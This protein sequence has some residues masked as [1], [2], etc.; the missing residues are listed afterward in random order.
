MCYY[1]IT[2]VL[3]SFRNN[4]H[5]LIEVKQISIRKSQPAS[6]I[7]GFTSAYLSSLHTNFKTFQ[8]SCHP[9]KSESRIKCV[10]LIISHV[11]LWYSEYKSSI[12][13]IC[14]KVLKTQISPINL[15]KDRLNRAGKMPVVFNFDI[16]NVYEMVAYDWLY[17]QYRGRLK[18]VDMVFK[19]FGNIE[20]WRLF[21]VC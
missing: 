10:I 12:Q 7:N 21:L 2:C 8:I 1:I 5:R 18:I 15:L 16:C 9:R 13:N 14:R 20:D 4:M 19:F 6:L 17:S 11:Y 3:Y